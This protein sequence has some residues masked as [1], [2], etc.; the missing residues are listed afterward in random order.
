MIIHCLKASGFRIIGEPIDI[1]FPEEGRIGI[2][3]QNESGKTTFLQAIEY[4]LYGLRRG[5]GAEGE[6][7]NLV[8]WGKNE[9]KLEIE[10]TS[11]QDT[12]ILQ[13]VF[14]AKSGH[15]ASLTPVIEGVK[16]K[17][18]SVTSLR[19]IEAKI[20][21]IT[22][23]DRDSFTK[24]IYV[25]QKDLDAL[26]ELAKSKR[27]QL[28]NKVMGIEVFDEAT[29]KVNDDLN[30]VESNIEIKKVEFEQVTKDKGE[31]EKQVVVREKLQKAKA[32]V[33]KK[34]AEQKL[35]LEE[36]E[37][38]VKK[39]DWLATRES[40]TSL[41]NQ[42]R[43]NIQNLS[44]KIQELNNLRNEKQG[45]ENEL[46]KYERVDQTLKALKGVKSIRTDIEQKILWK[47]EKKRTLN[48][49]S[50]Q[51]QKQRNFLEKNKAT[52]QHLSEY[53][54]KY[55]DVERQLESQQLELQQF[56]EQKNSELL[57]Y[58]VSEKDMGYL[59]ANLSKMKSHRLLIGILLVAV[60]IMLLS[61]SVIINIFLLAAAILLLAF[62]FIS[63]RR[64]QHL[65]NLSNLGV[66]IQSL[67]KNIGQKKQKIDELSQNF[68]KLKIEANYHSSAEIE[69][70]IS[71]ITSALRSETGL[72][73]FDALKAVLRKNEE[74]ESQ[75]ISEM[76]ILEK[77]LASLKSQL[78]A[79]SSEIEVPPDLDKR[80]EEY[81]AL[82]KKKAELN[83]K[84]SSTRA[85][86]Q[87]IEDENPQVGLE[88]LNE[89]LSRINGELE[90]LEKIKPETVEVIR[91]S[92]TA[93]EQV[94]RDL[95]TVRD[96][97]VALNEDLA[98]K[99]QGLEDV[100]KVIE[101]VKPGYN[102]YPALKAEI[103]ELEGRIQLL[104]RIAF[105]M[106]E[107]SKELRNKVIPHARFII[108]QILPTLTDGRYSDFEITEDLKFKVHSNEA[109]GYKEREIFSGG[110]QDQFLIALRLAFTQSI[111]DSRV[112]A[113][114]YSLLMDECISSSD[115]VRKQGIFEVLDLMKKTFSQIFVIA[116]EDISNFVDNHIVLARNEH[117]FTEIKS[118]S[119]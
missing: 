30:Q 20:E 39:Y 105:E 55:S 119:W 115:D 34:S 45:L 9:A 71:D 66:N 79:M 107:T 53:F 40:K 74:Q 2:V 26:R 24:L 46:K 50:A 25:R 91:Y 28:V 5:P 98:R 70:K 43:T 15:R 87:K 23:M 60:G 76:D 112:M 113:D 52:Y 38:L 14:G 62:G 17:S 68:D 63:L 61:M 48:E 67:S 72:E 78:N 42:T 19:D 92:E 117:G 44:A 41:Y 99:S 69:S 10:F 114:K 95:K 89:Q 84:L 109:G 7:E 59:T 94:K 83:G 33:E 86:I 65:E 11:G 73:S 104:E 82:S 27:E 1:S 116:H 90:I 111:L 93:H 108:N 3:G 37:I 31:Y 97:Y 101:G 100:E 16:D 81:E 18:N 4:A 36:K 77:T 29:A 6:R 75:L 103:S 85:N 110:T 80:I 35:L 8:T 22:G 13:R 106:K 54:E 51:A 21:Q 47:E 57:K 102:R 96:A 118:R 56:E 12:Y 58:K 32:K 64:Y 49:V 88:K